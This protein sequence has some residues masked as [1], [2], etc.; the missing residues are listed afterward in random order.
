M[1]DKG[2]FKDAIKKAEQILEKVVLK[3]LHETF[4][5]Y[6]NP[7]NSRVFWIFVAYLTLVYY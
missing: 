2:K 5:M 3:I 6:S 7:L 4:L 1:T